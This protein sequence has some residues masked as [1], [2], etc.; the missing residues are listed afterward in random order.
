ML[1]ELAS[2]ALGLDPSEAECRLQTFGANELPENA[3][4]SL[5]EIFIRQFKSPLIYVLLI[6]G[7]MSLAIRAYSDATFIFVVLLMNAGIG[8]YQE[9]RAEQS[10][11][12]LKSL[13]ASRTQ[14]LRGGDV[15]EI[16]AQFLVPGDVVL[17]ESGAKAPA[18]LRLLDTHDLSVDESVLTGESLAAHKHADLALPADTPLAER[19]NMVFAGS[20]I[21][22]GRGRGVVTATGPQTELGRIAAS[23]LGRVAAKAPLIMR[24]EKFT[25]RITI[26]TAVI[27]TLLVTISVAQGADLTATL[28]LAVALAVSAIPEGLPVALTVALSVGMQRMAQ[29]GVIVRRLVAVEAL[30]SCTYIA[31][32]KT[33]TLTV[34]QLTVRRIQ[35]PGLPAWEVTGEGLAPEGQVAF[36]DNNNFTSHQANVLITALAKTMVLP[37][38]AVLSQSDGNWTGHGDSVDLALLVFAHKVGVTKAQCL[39]ESPELDMIPYESE[40][41][42]AASAN[43]VDSQ[44]DTGIQAF[45]KGSLE[46]L[47]PMCSTMNTANG[48]VALDRQAIINQ[49]NTLASQG[50]RVL[51]AAYGPVGKPAGEPTGG[52]TDN[53]K[54][55]TCSYSARSSQLSPS[56]LQDLCFAGLV[57]MSD[58]PRPQASQSIADCRAAGI[59]VAMVTGDHPQTALAIAR[60]VGLAD[61]IRDVVTGMQLKEAANQGLQTL[62]ALCSSARV[63]ARVEPQQKLQI[64]ESLQ[65]QGHF[66]A[67]TGDGANDAPALRAAQVGVAMGLRGTDVA[68]ETSDIVIT[69]DNFSSIVAGIEQGRVAY[70]NVRKVIFLLLSTGAAEVILFVLALISGLPLP[71]LAVQ[72]LWLNLVT[73]GIQDVALAF[74]PSEGNELKQVPR[75][76]KQG[77]FDR[78][79]LQRVLLSAA[80]MGIV[81]FGAYYGLLAAGW[82]IDA[83]RNLVLLLMVL[84]E[85]LQ[86]LN[87]RSETRSVFSMN[88]LKNR[89]L[90]FSVIAA[91]ALHIGAMYT[92]GINEVL[93]LQPVSLTEWAMMLGL[94]C[95]LI[96]VNEA[97]KMVQRK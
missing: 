67:V 73:N 4:P 20:L 13:V 58:P 1:S 69:D 64:V 49:A 33:G 88:P 12:A 57:A 42:F 80:T 53:T 28:L 32:D 14:V 22:T 89:L 29:R 31:S 8:L 51:A 84:F 74:E 38:E 96:V 21:N 11:R 77:V 17:L 71:L 40:R 45:V 66:V 59:T 63:F 85:N 55:S 16:D 48:S 26:A 39:A 19:R 83:A 86:A 7:M 44:T 27:G 23:V 43:R 37:N 56:Q 61:D 35:F 34:N 2:S 50:L 18:D 54:A 90:L 9:Y 46:R 41:Q 72:L 6:A 87:S 25:H 30:G 47:L 70:A 75:P 92:P 36:A 81:A 60:E 10:A 79:M 78:V 24:M 91:Q 68:K 5:A 62:D 94:A 3:A 76:P 95:S 52:P 82:Q 15:F 65:R 93:G 97:Y